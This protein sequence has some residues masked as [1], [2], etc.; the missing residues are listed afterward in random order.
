MDPQNQPVQLHLLGARRAPMNQDEFDTKFNYMKGTRNRRISLDSHQ[1]ECCVCCRLNVKAPYRIPSDPESNIPRSKLFFT[2]YLPIVEWLG[3]YEIRKNIFGDISAGISLGLHSVAQGFAFSLLAGLPPICGLYTSFFAALIY[4]FLGTSKFSFFGSNMIICFFVRNVV[5]RHSVP[6]DFIYLLSPNSTQKP[7]F[8][9]LEQIKIVST[10]TFL[11]AAIQALLFTLRLDFIFSYISQQVLSG[12]SFGLGIRIV[13]N[14]LQ[15]ILHLKGNSCISELTLTLT[16]ISSKVSPPSYKQCAFLAAK[17]GLLNKSAAY[18]FPLYLRNENPATSINTDDCLVS[19]WDC[20]DYI[21]LY[22]MALSVCVILFLLFAKQILGPLLQMRVHSPVPFEFLLIVITCL[23]SELTDIKG[24]Y[25]VETLTHMSSGFPITI[26]QLGLFDDLIFDAFALAMLVFASHNR[27]TLQMSKDNKYSVDVQMEQVTLAAIG[28]V[29]SW[30]GAHPPGGSL[31][32]NMMAIN[33]GTN[34]M[35]SNLG[36]VIIMV[37]FIFGLSTLFV[38]LPVCVLSCL[39]FSALWEHFGGITK[40]AVLWKISKLDIFTWI[41]SCAVATVVGNSTF[42][43]F[44]SVFFALCTIIVRTQWPKFQLLV[45]V[46]GSGAYYAERSYY[47][48]ELLEDSGVA[49]VRF[50]APLLFNNCFQFKRDVFFVSENI[51][52]QILGVGIGTRTGS[53]K[54]ANAASLAGITKDVPMRSTLL[55]SGDI[56]PNYD[57]VSADSTITKVVIVDFSS[58]TIIDAS[59]LETMMEIHSEL[60]E[61]KVKLVFASVN[62]A[63]RNRFKEIGGFDAVP[64]SNFFP[65]VND[66]VLYSQQLGGMVAPSFHMSVSMNGYRDLITLSTATSHQDIEQGNNNS[67]V[68]E[69]SLGA[70]PRPSLPEARTSPPP[71]SPNKLRATTSNGN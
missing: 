45:N 14:Q 7:E 32:R 49:I 66:A 55:I 13:F 12:F 68:A 22:T 54:S 8:D 41:F 19:V 59:G 18:G 25:H 62:S 1:V 43:L 67:G 9:G 57:T 70:S 5:E 3:S 63:I 46:T 42:A 23:L 27:L 21:N 6:Y 48:S 26:P 20:L 4:T 60:A 71:S 2:K 53:M 58:I 47:G 52:G 34:S 65:S 64:K 10:L 40:F 15:H 50:E 24:R 56:V 31:S 37:P 44:S 39:V 38:S 51:K 29:S 30:F 17:N 61:K 36:V 33:A 69:H 16:S 28:V 35:L 11:A